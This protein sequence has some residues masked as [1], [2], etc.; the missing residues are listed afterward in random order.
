[1]QKSHN[2]A[3]HITNGSCSV[4]V[5][6]KAELQG[7]IISWDDVL[8][9]GP[10]PCGLTLKELSSLRAHYISGQGWAPLAE[11]LSKFDQRDR[12]LGNFN[13]YTKTILWF[14]HDLYDQLQLLQLLDWFA[15]HKEEDTNI[16]LI[17][18]DQFLG[19][20]SP[21]H[22]KALIG[23]EIP[24]TEEQF[25]L[26]Q[27]AWTAFC[28]PEPVLWQQLLLQDTSVL[29]FLHDSIH[30][31]LQEYPSIGNGLSRTEQ[32]ALKAV[33]TG[34]KTPG[35][36]FHF[37]QQQEEAMF[38]GDLV[39]WDILRQ[40]TQSDPPLLSFAGSG[41]CT[42]AFD[43]KISLSLTD[44]G[45]DVIKGKTNWLTIHPMDHRFGGVH[46]Q[47]DLF[48]CWD[49]AEMRLRQFHKHEQVLT[50]T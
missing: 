14:E 26:A 2:E 41:E 28:A 40:F 49:N 27:Q 45:R 30:R 29:P 5:M 31:F 47:P 16:A 48:W 25:S 3:L 43:S 8:H 34:R 15:R 24:V 35:E 20:M 39:F 21:E 46:L 22:L 1:M 42:L 38:M 19:P 17:C 12:V 6:R 13:N 33:A 36:I 11:V 9:C 18:V 10:V 23:T 4:E 44:I 37:A 7:E 50:F 32:T